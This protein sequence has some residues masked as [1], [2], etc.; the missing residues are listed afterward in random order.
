MLF[1][2]FSYTV[3]PTRTLGFNSIRYNG[4]CIR[5]SV[6]Q[7]DCSNVSDVKKTV[8]QWVIQVHFCLLTC[9]AVPRHT[10]SSTFT[11][12]PNADAVNL[13]NIDAGLFSV[14]EI[15]WQLFNS[16]RGRGYWRSTKL[17]AFQKKSNAISLRKYGWLKSGVRILPIPHS[18][19]AALKCYVLQRNTLILP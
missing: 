5:M 14:A 1:M 3:F 13:L 11:A 17:R 19:M 6:R 9:Y 2:P 10:T 16:F 12:A 18:A 8:K 7:R 4:D 15:A